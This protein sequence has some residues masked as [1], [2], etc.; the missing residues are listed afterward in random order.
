MC[1]AYCAC[2]GHDVRITPTPSPHPHLLLQVCHDAT[3]KLVRAVNSLLIGTDPEL[4]SSLC[5]SLTVPVQAT[6]ES[7]L[8]SDVFVREFRALLHPLLKCFFVGVVPMETVCMLM[9][10]QVLTVIFPSYDPLP[11]FVTSMLL[12]ARQDL[13]RCRNV[14]IW[15]ETWSTCVFLF[16]VVLLLLQLPACLFSAI[17]GPHCLHSSAG[18]THSPCAS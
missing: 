18:T 2:I 12:L 14:S 6:G 13:L 7:P 9:D 11:Y 5:N 4:H 10:Q 3:T 16:A 8:Q 15:C 1:V 17:P